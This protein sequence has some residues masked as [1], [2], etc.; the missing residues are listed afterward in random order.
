MGQ[1][2]LGATCRA[3]GGSTPSGR[4]GWRRYA[5]LVLVCLATLTVVVGAP[6]YAH[7]GEGGFVLLLPT[8]YYLFGGTMAV[9]ISFGLVTLA[10][11]GLLQRVVQ[12]R[13]RLCCVPAVDPRVA[14][15]AASVLLVVLVIAGFLGN[16]DPLDNPLPLTVWTIW[17]VGLPMLQ[18]LVGNVWFLFN[19][20]IMPCHLSQGLLRRTGSSPVDPLLRYP[21]WLGYWP[22]ML[23]F[24][25]FAWF[26]LIYPAPAD[27][28]R[29]A[30]AVLVYSGWT[31]CGMLLFGETAWLARGEPFSIFLALVARISPV[32][33]R[34]EAA[35]GPRRYGLYLT[36]PGANLLNLPP[37]SVSGVLFVLLVLATVT[38]DGFG[39]TFWWLGRIGVNPLDFP[40]RSAVMDTMTLGLLGTW[41]VLVAGYFAAI[42]WGV[43]ASGSAGRGGLGR[44]AG[45]LI[46]SIL[47]ISIAY[48]IAH[49]LTAFLVNIQDAWVAMSDPF[50]LDWNLFDTGGDHVSTAL[51]T[52]YQSVRV[53]W[54]IEALVIVLGHVL[55]I[56]VAHLLV[57]RQ[58]G[59]D[60]AVWRREIPL[61]A[62]MTLYT[63]FGL[64]LL[65]TPSAG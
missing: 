50:E 41:L 43:A 26:E 3:A 4:P 54:N 19:P 64:W 36:W 18:L 5:T 15:S 57:R 40:G 32:L 1:M 63:L 55:A 42:A 38:F 21:D 8:A 44:A 25:G 34:L 46:V 35:A 11:A 62:V 13:W 27:P 39:R 37:L 16:R 65:A 14:R 59:D 30:V 45:V 29:L 28:A 9:A 6:A 20:W 24:F 49:Y 47:P 60:P 12:W 51:L 10:P 17:W 23:A 61:A 31:L 52:D 7:T 53:I 33:V 48:H 2:E 22:A 56:A 58:W